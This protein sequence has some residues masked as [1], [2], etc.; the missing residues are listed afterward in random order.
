MDW[1][2]QGIPAW[3]RGVG[4]LPRVQMMTNR[5][6]ITLCTALA[7]L[8]PQGGCGLLTTKTVAM[9]AGKEVV[10]HEYKKHKKH[11]DEKKREREEAANQQE[12]SAD[13]A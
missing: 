2:L 6:F 1:N 10:K 12:E 7:L 5:A 11:R 8:F 4:N 9:M 3:H 13:G